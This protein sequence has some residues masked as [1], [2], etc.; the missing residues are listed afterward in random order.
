M[1]VLLALFLLPLATFTNLQ[2]RHNYYA[3]ANGL[4]LIAAVGIICVDLWQ[5]ESILRRV[6]GG[7]GIIFCAIIT[8][9]SYH[10]LTYFFPKQ[11]ITD[12]LSTIKNDFDK[13]IPN[14]DDIIVVFG[15]GWSSE[16]PYYFGRRAVMFSSD[17]L[18]AQEFQET[19]RN[20]AP[21]RVGAILFYGD[22]R[23]D[24]T[25]IREAL[26][27]FGFRWNLLMEYGQL[28]VYFNTSLN[29]T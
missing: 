6:C 11:G 17:D 19:L 24:T 8:F 27:A 15:A 28:F 16:F 23:N 26:S 9:S 12:N 3:Y 21:Y 2:Y 5:S 13:I 18:T 1:T 7:G 25:L 29:K 4:F 22:T 10:Y 20:L 14:K